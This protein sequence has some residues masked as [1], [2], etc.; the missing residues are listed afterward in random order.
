MNDP[1]VE[2]MRSNYYSKPGSDISYQYTQKV[3]LLVEFNTSAGV[4]LNKGVAGSKNALNSYTILSGAAN[5]TKGNHLL[6][7]YDST[8][9]KGEKSKTRKYLVKKVVGKSNI[10]QKWQIIF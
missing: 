2:A 3:Y 8:I 6:Y 1:F 7:S 5:G 9:T 10:L 4:R